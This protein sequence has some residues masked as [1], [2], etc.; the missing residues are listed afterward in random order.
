MWGWIVETARGWSL[1]AIW[2]RLFFA[3]LVGVLIGI[4]R[5]MK[6]RGAGVKTHVLVCLGSAL[7]MLTSEYMMHIFPGSK[8]DMA[9]MGAQVISGVGFLGVG[10]IM[11]TGHNQ[12]RGLTTAAGLWA[13]ACVGLAVGI[14]F[15]DGAVYTLVLIMITLKIMSKVDVIMHDHGK[16]LDFYLEFSNGKNVAQFV[17]ELRD[18]NLRIVNFE[19]VKSKIKGEGPSATLR[20]EVRDR[21]MRGSLLGELQNMECVRFVEEL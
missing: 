4:D 2:I 16:L 21:K 6:R 19:L 7:V 17:E 14:G 3:L 15:V 12:I 5:G 13:C 11:V 1:A 18:R 10:T 9:R 8:A 20:V